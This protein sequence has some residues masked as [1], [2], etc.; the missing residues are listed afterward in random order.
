M[1]KKKKNRTNKAQTFRPPDSTPKKV[2]FK[3]DNATPDVQ[4]AR[5]WF[6]FRHICQKDFC[7][8]KCS[9]EKFKSYADKLRILSELD[10]KTIESSPSET[11]G[12]E[13]IPVRNIKGSL[14]DRFSA[15][16]NVWVFRFGGPGRVA[17]KTSGRIAGIR[18]KDRFFVLFIDRD[19]TLYDHGS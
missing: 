19:F 6:S 14:P 7:V 17:S 5:P 8:K 4:S 9:I 13:L 2:E 15:H 16:E 11:N 3:A 18:D 1:S 12:F 10:W